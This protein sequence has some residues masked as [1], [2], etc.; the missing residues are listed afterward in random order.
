[1]RTARRD[2]EPKSKSKEEALSSLMALCARA[3]RSTGDA[4]R[5]MMRWG[6]ARDEQ[7]GVIDRLIADRFLDDARYA[8]AYVRD[9]VN[10]SGW[11][12]YKIERQLLQ[13]GITKDIIE[14]ELSTLNQESMQNRLITL[15]ERRARTIKYSTKYQLRDKLIRYGASQGYDFD[16][17][18]EAVSQIV[19]RTKTDDEECY[20]EYF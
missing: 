12:A 18:K 4:R 17:L 15:L 16:S 9:K 13:K 14:A 10:L 3:E 5:L 8:A 19:S 11:G 7:Q 20:E 2:I 1:M 6:V